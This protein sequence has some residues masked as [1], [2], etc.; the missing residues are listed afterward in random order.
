MCG[1][2]SVPH[3]TL[4]SQYSNAE[5]KKSKNWAKIAAGPQ[6]GDE[7]ALWQRLRDRVYVAVKNVDARPA[8]RKRTRAQPTQNPVPTPLATDAPATSVTIQNLAAVCTPPLSRRLVIATWNPSE[9]W[10]GA[11]DESTE[12]EQ[13][14][15]QK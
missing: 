13:E 11:E 9:E 4:R 5:R 8:V 1:L 15:E 12:Q 14:Q 2:D 6:T 7:M 10:S 3:T